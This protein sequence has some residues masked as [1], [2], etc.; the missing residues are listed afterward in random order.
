LEGAQFCR[1]IYC[2]VA[3]RKNEKNVFV[4]L[5]E[6]KDLLPADAGKQQILRFAQ[7]DK[8]VLKGR[9]AHGNANYTTIE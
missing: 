2:R 4:I 6:A 5:S 8:F 3:V 1:C 7:D 9:Q